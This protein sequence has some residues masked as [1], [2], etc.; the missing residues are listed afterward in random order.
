MT[1]QAKQPT[2]IKQ[3]V[4]HH[5]ADFVPVKVA[6]ENKTPVSVHNSSNVSTISHFT[7]PK[8][9]QLDNTQ[10]LIDGVRL[11]KNNLNKQLYSINYNSVNSS[12]LPS[13][14]YSVPNPRRKK[15]SS[16]NQSVPKGFAPS[17]FID[18]ADAV[19]KSP[20]YSM[21]DSVHKLPRI[22]MGVPTQKNL[23]RISNGPSNDE[24]EFSLLTPL[25]VGPSRR[26][27][28]MPSSIPPMTP[29]PNRAIMPINRPI[30]RDNAIDIVAG[31]DEYSAPDN[32]RTDG[33]VL[34]PRT[35]R[36]VY[37]ATLKA[38]ERE[39]KKFIT[40]KK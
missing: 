17:P 27:F 7:E 9:H 5:I 15:Q 19:L 13:K 1:I 8:S 31:Q 36:W 25:R 22:S 20:L 21:D 30:A 14:T 39:R 4:G 38:Y 40:S 34:N 33:R 23:K 10:A 3:I 2:E 28:V 18:N 26:P 11:T 32:T 12:E 37:P 6:E 35:G 24:N 29:T 16:G